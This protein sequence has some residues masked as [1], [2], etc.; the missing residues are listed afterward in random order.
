MISA[1]MAG[2]TLDSIDPTAADFTSAPT[3]ALVFSVLH[4]L[5]FLDAPALVKHSLF[6]LSMSF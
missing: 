1:V 3:N 5:L 4:D 2:V 6:K